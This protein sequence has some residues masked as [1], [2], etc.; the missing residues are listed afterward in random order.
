MSTATQTEVVNGYSVEQVD[1]GGGGKKLGAYFQ[2]GPNAWK[3]TDLK[4]KT[5]FEFAETNRDQ[6]SVY[7]ED[8]SR[9]V[10]LQIDLHRKKVRY[11]DPNT[12]IRDQYDV[13]SS[14]AVN[15]LMIAEAMYGSL[16]GSGTQ[17]GSF[18][19]TGPAAWY[20]RNAEGQKTFE[21]RETNR[22][23][24]SVYLIDS[25][26]DVSIQIDIWT[27]KV[28]YSRPNTPR[29]EQYSVLSVAPVNG[30]I[31]QEAVFGEGANTFGR[32]RQEG[33]TKNWQ[34]IDRDGR[35]TFNFVENNRDEWSAYLKDSSR[36]VSIQIDNWTSKIVYS[37]ANSPPRDLYELLY[38]KS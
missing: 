10:D 22:D 7:L 23:D 32:F 11:S 2:T 13:L 9:N 19:Q 30:W 20:E 34:E 12:P 3:E 28:F 37:H 5:T 6:W 36:D 21:F 1:F 4:G 8:R 26:R 16:D 18:F 14:A 31:V 35:V 29:R 17:L 27:Q 15:G 33:G 24:W 25:S 38:A